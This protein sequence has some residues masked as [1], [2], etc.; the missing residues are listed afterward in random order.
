ME[1]KYQRCCGIDIHK[2][3]VVAC[4]MVSGEPH[5]QDNE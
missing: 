4:V 1:V 3:M 2:Q 5:V